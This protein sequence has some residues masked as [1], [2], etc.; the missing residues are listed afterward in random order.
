MNDVT[1]FV[2]IEQTCP[3]WRTARII[4]EQGVPER[5]SLGINQ[6]DPHIL[7][8]DREWMWRLSNFAPPEDRPDV[9]RRLQNA[10]VLLS[11]AI[12]LSEFLMQL[13]SATT[14]IRAMS[15]LRYQ[16]NAMEARGYGRF[17]DIIKHAL[18]IRP[19]AMLLDGVEYPLPSMRINFV[20]SVGDFKP[21]P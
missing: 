16:E 7:E 21:A 3:L 2:E 6:H 4:L 13:S 20:I 17:S 9:Y 14:V 11:M 12:D 15:A 10:Q 1:D 19:T 5:L 8:F 18:G